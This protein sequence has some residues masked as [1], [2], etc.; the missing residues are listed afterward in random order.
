MRD[1]VASEGDSAFDPSGSSQPYDAEGP[2]SPHGSSERAQS[3]HGDSGSESTDLTSIS[4]GL[5]SLDMHDL[6]SG[7]G[8]IG[9]GSITTVENLEGLRVDQKI[10]ILCEMFP[11]I[12]EFDIGYI[13][14]KVHYNFGKAV[15]DLL[16]QAFLESEDVEG[17]G[18]VLKKGIDGFLEPVDGRGR[19]PKGKRRN[20]TR[21][22]SSTPAPS[23]AISTQSVNTLSRWDR[24]KEDVEFL[25]QRIHLPRS[26]ISSAYHSSGASLPS[27]IAV[28]STS[29]ASLPIH[30]SI[31]L[32][33][34]TI[35]AHTAELAM[36]FPMLPAATVKGLVQLTHPSTASAHELARAALAPP[37]SENGKL[38]PHY[39]TRPPSPSTGSQQ[40]KAE[41]LAMPFD[42]ATRRA[43]ASAAAR[44]DAFTQANAAYRRSKSKPL[45]G[46]AA[47]YYS[48][49]GRDALASQ[50]RYE[51]AAAD[52]RVTAQS[53]PG[54][55]DL[56]GVNV[57]DAVRIAQNRIE[58][59]W[60]AEGLEW[61]R[62]GK[63]MGGKG[64]R[65]VTG[66]GR[67]SEGG[68][69]KLGPAV[70]AM[71]VREGWK[72]EV[73]QGVIN[74]TGKTRR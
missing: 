41:L 29:T 69:G 54:E 42:T 28:L 18:K 70:G 26:T 17:D 52:A 9:A 73:E 7:D 33:N 36:D 48:A 40:P 31:P 34:D 44:S 63:V 21:R 50:R 56:H 49:V 47:S 71:L 67:H 62:A 59:W 68:R 14:K 2:S 72:V 8:D 66:V 64:F 65:I 32:I 51:T 43:H 46:G 25:A 60:E 57:K 61:A 55:I 20:Q 5:K 10:D 39:V 53:R 30:H 35:E 45:M 11:T 23:E 16:S 12:K 27:A 6:S 3:W 13:L 37:T 4:Y 74:V 19:K 24:A 15:E 22:T 1:N 38:I 58:K